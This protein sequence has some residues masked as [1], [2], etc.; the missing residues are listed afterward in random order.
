MAQEHPEDFLYDVRLVERHI[1]RGLLTRDAVRA[2][3]ESRRDV[4]SQSDT[5]NLDQIAANAKAKR[6]AAS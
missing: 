1:T 3:N 5:L 2:Y 6:P 4:A